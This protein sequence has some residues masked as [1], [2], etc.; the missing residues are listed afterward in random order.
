M[1]TH[2]MITDDKTNGGDKIQEKK[3]NKNCITFWNTSSMV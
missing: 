2:L 3:R 1:L